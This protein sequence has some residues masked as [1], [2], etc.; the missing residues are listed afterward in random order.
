MYFLLLLFLLEMLLVPFEHWILLLISRSG[1]IPGLSHSRWLGLLGLVNIVLLLL[2]SCLNLLF[3]SHDLLFTDICFLIL[4]P[5]LYGSLSE[6]TVLFFSLDDAVDGGSLF[7]DAAMTCL[8][9]ALVDEGVRARRRYVD[10][11]E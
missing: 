3:F 10:C 11:I 1:V 7:S 9:P 2:L 4:V 8:G 5:V 6:A